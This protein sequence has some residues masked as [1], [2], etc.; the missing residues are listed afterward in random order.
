[1]NLENRN[2]T[3]IK[4]IEKQD[5]SFQIHVA[6]NKFREVQIL[7]S[8]ILNILVKEKDLNLSDIHVIAPDI[9][10]YAP[11]IHMIF[12]DEEN[13]LSYKIADL[14]FN[15][16]SQLILG[17]DKLFSLANSKW[18]KKDILD[19]FENSLFQKKCGISHE[20]LFL[21]FEMIEKANISFGINEKH[22][23][24][25]LEENSN[26]NHFIQKSFEKGLSRILLGMIFYLNEDFSDKLFIYDFPVGQ[27]DFSNDSVIIDKFLKVI[28]NLIDDLKII[29]ERK[30]LSM[31]DWREYLKKIIDDYFLVKDS[32]IEK[33]ALDNCLNFLQDLK[34][35][36]FRFA[37]C[38]Y[39]FETIYNYFKKYISRMQANFNLN[40]EQA[41]FFSSFSL[42]FLPAKAVF[43]IG[44]K[45]NAI[46]F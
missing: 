9:N 27:L 41:I 3:N 36:E 30:K 29:E 46:E 4:N 37:S 15:N 21:L 34:K 32:F 13:S 10:E 28:F 8:N 19:L 1:M 39:L 22:I 11:Y 18:E 44:L 26:I 24:K 5:D 35:I 38:T 16:A 12:N 25:F 2:Y 42:S 31:N 14:S 40:N 23:A 20:E 43:I 7:H 33:S 17:I 6:A 45:S